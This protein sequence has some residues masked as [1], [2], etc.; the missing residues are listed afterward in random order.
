MEKMNKVT[1]TLI[2]ALMVPAGASAEDQP[3]QA[4]I[5]E[6]RGQ[7]LTRLAGGAWQPAKVGT[8]L[9]EKDEVRTGT[10][11]FAKIRLDGGKVGDVDLQEK[12]Y[13]R[14]HTMGM[15]AKGNKT[16]LLDLAIGKVLIHA[17]K[18]KGNSKFEVRTPTATTGVRGT[19]FQVSVDE[20]KKKPPAQVA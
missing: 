6:V 9:K 7:V 10:G 15:D 4:S 17:Q 13:F 19:V 20:K 5:L 1:L 14:L 11:S 18:L 8:I 12:S 2:L 3:R 16:T